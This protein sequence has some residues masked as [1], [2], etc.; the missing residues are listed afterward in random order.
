MRRVSRILVLVL[1]LL[2]VT[3]TAAY[4]RPNEWSTIGTHT[5]RWGETIF[6]IA[7]AY[8][9]DPWAIASHNGITN[10]SVI[11][12]RQV[13]NI[14]NAYARIPGGPRCVRQF[15]TPNGYHPCTCSTYHTI[16]CGE[17]LY[18]ISLKYNVSMWRIARCNGI[19]NLNYIR[20]GDTLCIPPDP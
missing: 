5:V 7:R 1:A 16:A 3:T 6:C 4:A 12:P 11:K 20:W 15:G 10:P 8:H 2:L 13:L 9:V 19:R 14:P 18:R 17:N